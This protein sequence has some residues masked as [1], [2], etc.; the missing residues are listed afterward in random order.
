MR[1]IGLVAL[2][3]ALLASGCGDADEVAPQLTETPAAVIPQPGQT[4]VPPQVGDFPVL[5]SRACVEVAQFYFEALGS[6]EFARAALVWND[7]V[8]D[9]ARLEAVFARYRE[10]RIEWNEPFVEGAAGS[11]YCTVSGVL[12]DAADPAKPPLEGTLLLRRVNE[13][14]GATPDQLRWTLQ[15]STFVERLERSSRGEP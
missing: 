2:A 1:R 5:S 10:P 11:L 12:T 13:I 9:A 8:I 6:R 3:A 14:P 4:K 15:S 7:P